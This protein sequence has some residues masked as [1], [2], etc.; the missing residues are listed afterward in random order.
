MVFIMHRATQVKPTKKVAM[1]QAIQVMI[2]QVTMTQATL[3]T[4]PEMVTN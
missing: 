1:T 2:T 3:M 4:I